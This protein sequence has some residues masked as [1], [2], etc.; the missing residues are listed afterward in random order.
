MIRPPEA[1]ASGLTLHVERATAGA[2]QTLAL[3]ALDDA[4]RLV[5]VEKVD[6]AADKTTAS[7]VLKIPAELRNR[8]AS[9]SIEGEDSA[10]GVMLLDDRWRQRPVGLIT[11]SEETNAQ[12][13]LSDL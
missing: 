11:E 7:L 4:G 13:L 8:I 12:P 6:F 5:S 9:L 1:T 10:G 2:P 3:R